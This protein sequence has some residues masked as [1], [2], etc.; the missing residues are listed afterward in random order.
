MI[1]HTS[2]RREKSLSESTSSCLIL[3]L[4]IVVLIAYFKEIREIGSISIIGYNKRNEKTSEKP[5]KARGYG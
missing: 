2:S 4:A 3:I 1:N 5:L